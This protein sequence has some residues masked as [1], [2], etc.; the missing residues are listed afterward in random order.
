[1]SNRINDCKEDGCDIVSEYRS[2]RWKYNKW[3]TSMQEKWTISFEKLYQISQLST[4]IKLNS[5]FFII[6][7]M[8]YMTTIKCTS[9][10]DCRTS[11]T[12]NTHFSRKSNASARNFCLFMIPLTQD[13]TS[14]ATLSLT[15]EV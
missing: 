15:R 4:E 2:C 1:M 5:S 10:S 8:R 9:N 12:A 11:N 3:A 6:H 13:K 7:A 14:Q